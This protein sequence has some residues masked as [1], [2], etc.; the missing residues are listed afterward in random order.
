MGS[1]GTAWAAL[2]READERE[3][4]EL[5]E[6]RACMRLLREAFDCIRDM[7]RK[8]AREGE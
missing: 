7:E 3:A 4:R 6:A 1:E 8:R 2:A 5:S